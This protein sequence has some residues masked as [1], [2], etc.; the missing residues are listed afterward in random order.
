MSHVD[1]TPAINTVEWFFGYGG[2]HLGLKRCLPNLRLVAACEIEEF[3]IENLLAKMENGWVEAAPIWSD[4]RAFPWEPFV[5][6]IDLFVAS[7]PCQPFSAAGKRGGADDPRHLWPVVL[8]WILRVRPLCVFCENVE[9]HVSLG[10]S[11]V[12]SDLEEAGY[13]TS[14]GIFSASEVGA[15]HQRKRVFI[16][17]HRKCEGLEGWRQRMQPESFGC[18][19]SKHISEGSNLLA[20][21]MCN[22]GAEG[23]EVRQGA[24]GPK[25]IW[26]GES[27]GTWP[28]RP[29]QPQ[30]EWEPPRVVANSKE[31][32]LPRSGESHS[33]EW[34]EHPSDGS[35]ILGGSS[36]SSND[37]GAEIMGDSKHNGLPSSEIS[38]GISEESEEGGMQE[39]EGGCRLSSGNLGDSEGGCN[40][41]L[42]SQQQGWDTIGRPMQEGGEVGDPTGTGL[43]VGRGFGILEQEGGVSETE[44]SQPSPSI[45]QP[46]NS[47]GEIAGQAE[48]SL[49]GNPNGTT[50]GV[51]HAELREPNHSYSGADAE[52][53]ATELEHSEC[54][55]YHN[56]NTGSD[57]D[58]HEGSLGE[59]NEHREAVGASYADWGQLDD[60]RGA[61][62]HRIPSQQ[63]Q[64]DPAPW[65]SSDGHLYVSCDNRT[66]ELRLLGNGVVPATAELAFR[67]LWE[68]LT[69][70]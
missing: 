8:N 39:L 55:G 35:G 41:Q 49:G 18:R 66:D 45:E 48:P 33:S 34:Q 57:K 70:E 47:C 24:D 26:N 63:W 65:E 30:Y 42:P 51:G 64:E 5:D 67:T 22:G 29:G 38:R 62:Q 61:E 46:I 56:S 9:G 10:L 58:S 7:Y 27:W 31:P 68:E 59:V 16:M 40:G 2:N 1:S 32:G 28:S 52:H 43:Q 54:D 37:G 69:N 3:A 15:P 13:R 44:G 12:I 17:A 21:A 60:T 11:T 50:C 23:R 20:H 53:G 4:C 19:S 36:D 25:S 14:W 6:R